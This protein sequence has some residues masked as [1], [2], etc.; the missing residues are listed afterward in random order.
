M[1]RRLILHQ[2]DRFEK[3]VGVSVDWTRHVFRHS[4]RLFFKL[5]KLRSFAQSRRALPLPAWHVAV[6]V[7]ARSADCGPCVQIAVNIARKDGVDAD[8]LRAVVDQQPNVLSAELQDIYRF[9]ESVMTHSGEEDRIR[10]KIRTRYGEEGLIEF[11][12]ALASGPVIPTIKRALGFAT[13][14]SKV[15]FKV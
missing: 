3:S 12:F 2:L 6:I 8:V 15:T 1:I 4:L 5:T 9:S 10:E 7:A 14:C 13:S 11:A